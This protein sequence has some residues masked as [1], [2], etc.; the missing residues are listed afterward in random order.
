MKLKLSTLILFITYFGFSQQYDTVYIEETDID[1]NNKI[2]KP[3][4]VF[5]YD[6]EIIIDNKAYKLNTNKGMAARRGF[7]LV[8]I[9]ADS[10]GVDQIHLIVRPVEDAERTNKNQT[11]ISFLQGPIYDSM[12]STGVVENEDNVWIHPI[13]TG[14]FNA[15]QTGPFPFVKYP[16]SIGS[17]WTDQM[18]IGQ[19]WGGEL[20]G[21][22]DGQLLQSYAYKLT[23]KESLK[24]PIGDVDC[25]VIESTAS[26]SFGTTILKSYF[27]E[28]YGFVRM[29]YCL[30]N[31][32][33][34]NLWLIDTKTGKEFNDMQ[35]LFQTKQYIKQ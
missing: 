17:T 15:L 28:K 6:Y 1:E 33:K 29:E 14:F 23:G 27:S 22:W 20:W 8:A 4:N 34:V 16:L 26:S 2:Y 24:T 3:G 31:D 32:L 25:Y 19:A 30:F 7:E 5:V 12:S 10:I 9:D 13:R 18:M 11:Q 21:E 35:A